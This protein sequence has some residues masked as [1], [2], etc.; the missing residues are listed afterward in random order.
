[1][2]SKKEDMQLLLV[3]KGNEVIPLV[4]IYGAPH[5]LGSHNLVGLL[6]EI[7]QFAW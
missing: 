3:Q 4:S 5:G 1:M 6:G 7:S 2:K